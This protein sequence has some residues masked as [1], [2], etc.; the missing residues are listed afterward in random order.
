M[1]KTLFAI[2]VVTVFVAS[3]GIYSARALPDWF[4]ES[5]ANNDFANDALNKQL[6]N[7]G[8]DLLAQKSMDILRGQVAF[9]ED[10]FNAI[11]LASLKADVD[12]RKLL[13]V[14]DGIRAFLREGE[15]QLSAVINLDK[16]AKVEPK[17]REAVE[18]FD[19]LFWIIEDNR[20]AVTVYGKPVV[21]KG[22]LA[23]D[24]SFHAKV[25]EVVF[26][27]ETLRSLKIPVEQAQNTYLDIQYLS[28]KGVKV[29]P[30]KIAFS[31]RP[32]F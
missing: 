10:E 19:R 17:A 22:G 16:L 13:A 7:G 31:V 21:Y 30:K 3:Y 1:F 29:S 32:R 18:K 28:L 15:V 2:V 4:D 20:I 6:T 11:F 27:N 8:V 12:G 25:G 23:V 14:S 5:K 26:S 24:D 9:N